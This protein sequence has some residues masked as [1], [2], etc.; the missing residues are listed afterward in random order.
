MVRKPAKGLKS[1]RPERRLVDNILIVTEGSKTEKEYLDWLK[2]YFKFE[3]NRLINIHLEPGNHKSQPDQVVD[4]TLSVEN[5]KNYNHVYILIDRDDFDISKIKSAIKIANSEKFKIL[6]SYPCIEYWFLL[7][8]NNP[9]RGEYSLPRGAA[10]KSQLK[11]KYLNYENNLFDFFDSINCCN[12]IFAGI[13]GAKKVASLLA[14]SAEDNM[15]ANP[16]VMF[17]LLLSHLEELKVLLETGNPSKK[18]YNNKYKSKLTEINSSVKK[19]LQN[20]LKSSEFK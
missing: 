19:R 8:W 9:P 3:N 4:H 12:K 17:D 20:I 6:I 2:L 11:K 15:N 1:V 5:V 13:E 16:S 18:E 7:H 14:A 10:C